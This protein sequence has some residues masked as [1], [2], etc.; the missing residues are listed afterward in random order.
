MYDCPQFS[1]WADTERDISAWLGNAMQW[2][3]AKKIYEWEKLVIDSGNEELLSIWGKLQCSDNFYYMSTKSWND[4]AVHGYFSP[5]RSP[6]D[7][8]LHYMNVISDLEIACIHP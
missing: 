7:A 6:Y 5:F 3:A 8:Y 2:D 1:S 4:G